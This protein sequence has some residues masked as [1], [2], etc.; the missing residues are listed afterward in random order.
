MN[1]STTPT[2]VSFQARDWFYLSTF[3]RGF[4]TYDEISFEL[5]TKMQIANP[6]SGTTLVEVTSH[7]L[8]KLLNLFEEAY[9][10]HGKEV[11]KNTTNRIRAALLD[12]NTQE[13]T[14][15]FTNLDIEAL[16]EENTYQEIGRKWLRGKLG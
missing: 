12:L 10:R 6:P 5:K 9:K 1:T 13:I 4:E 16:E 14:T 2:T 7:P 3:M 8:G 11:G 15:Y